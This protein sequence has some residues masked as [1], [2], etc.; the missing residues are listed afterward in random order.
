MSDSPRR[1]LIS[2]SLRRGALALAFAGLT[3][4]WATGASAQG[5]PPPPPAAPPPPQA[6]PPDTYVVVQPQVMVQQPGYYAPPGY[7]PPGYMPIQPGAGTVGPKFL[8]YEE[9]DPVPPGYHKKTRIRVGLVAGG[10]S[11]FGVSYLLSIMTA[12]IGQLVANASSSIDGEPVKKDYGPMLIPVVGPFIAI[13]TTHANTGGAFGLTFL[14]LTQAGGMAMFIV[15]LAA[16]TTRLVRNDI[17]K[18]FT[19]TPTIAP[20]A[21]GLGA[22]GSF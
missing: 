7:A 2:P 9:G 21:Y 15:G 19:L 10:A 6:P 8:E 17:A 12:G 22:V 4:A 3:S 18:K 20:G 13:P 14:G 16:P 11:M 5:A 1:G